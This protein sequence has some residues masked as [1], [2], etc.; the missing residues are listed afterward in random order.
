MAL[1]PWLTKFSGGPKKLPLALVLKVPYTLQIVLAVGLTGWLS[2]R[3][4]RIAVHQLALELRQETADHVSQYIE[5]QLQTAQQINQANVAAIELGLLPLD[6]F[7]R[8]GQFFWRQMQIYDVGYINFANEAG[9]FIGVERTA[10]NQLLINETRA[11]AL[12]Q[13]TV[14]ETDSQGDRTQGTVLSAPEPVTAE[15]WYADAAVAGQPVWSDLYPWDDQPDVLSLSASYPLYDTQQQLLGVIG[16]DL[17][18]SQ[19]NDFLQ[20]LTQTD[21][22]TIFVMEPD[23][24]LVASSSR[25]PAYQ[26]VGGEAQQL[27][28]TASPD[29]VIQATA[30]QLLEQSPP[31]SKILSRSN[32]VFEISGIAHYVNVI[33]CQNQFGLDWHIVVVVP[34]TAFIEQINHNTRITVLMCLLAAAIAVLSCLITSRW[35]SQPIHELVVASQEIAKGNLNQS[36]KTH[37]IQE[38]EDLSQTFNAMANQLQAM[39]TEM[40]ERVAQRTAELAAAK[41]QA[42]HANDSKTQFLTNV[43]HELRTPLNVILGFTQVILADQQLPLK[44]QD[45]FRRIHQ[46][47]QSLLTLIGSILKVTQLEKD[48]SA[49][50]VCFNFPEFLET[51][52]HQLQP[53]AAAKRLQLTI[54]PLTELPCFIFTDES[55][56]RDVLVNLT[57]NAISSLSQGRVSIQIWAHSNEVSSQDEDHP[58]ILQFEVEHSSD[59]LSLPRTAEVN[60]NFV[61]VPLEYDLNQGIG[62]GGLYE[63]RICPINGWQLDL[64]SVFW[65]EN[66]FPVCHSD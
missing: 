22:K 55:K 57:D 51:L 39:F 47:G 52:Y 10:D 40:E 8:M 7:D 25:Y 1:F 32:P 31:E 15:G 2:L 66:G 9:E 11:S 49:Y 54:Q 62:L 33:P 50:N 41:K 6:D 29:I 56:L 5:D 17:L 61:P 46:N 63:S 38:F 28:A 58:W 59:G 64:S 42:E 12:D 65:L 48:I 36:L 18:V 14:Y 43:S 19:M 26:V 13:M 34:E 53:Q 44:H 45:A 23:G 35:I 20:T 16:V 3:N 21:G 27:P 60:Q 30:Q 24:T 37:L 4:G